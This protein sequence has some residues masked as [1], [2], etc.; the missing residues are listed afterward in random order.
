MG[1]TLTN[2]AP[3]LFGVAQQVS[4]EPVGALDG[5]N[6]SFDD[7][8]VAV[9]DDVKIPVAPAQ[10]ATDFTPG[11]AAASGADQIADSETVKITASKKVTW[12]LTGE[13]QR[14]LA[15]GGSD[16]EWL[17]Q[18]IAQGMRTLKNLA[19]ADALTAIKSGA[20]RAIGAAGTTPFASNIDD[21]AAMYK[22][23]RDNGAPMADLSLVIDTSA[24]FNLR[25]LGIIQQAYQAGSEAERRTGQLLKQFG[26]SIRE[27]GGVSLH[28]KGTGASYVTG[29]TGPYVKGVRDVPLVTG[30]GTVLAGD[31]VT[32]AADTNNKFI[33][34]TGIAAPGTI[35]LGRPGLRVSVANGNALT[36]GNN[37]TPNVAFERGA[38]VGAMRPPVMPE[39]PTIKQLPISDGKGMTFLLLEIAQYGQITWELHAAWGFK[40]VQ[41]EHVAVL[42]G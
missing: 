30:T 10:A 33:V 2:L 40:V 22:L 21:I 17:R 7:K 19:E 9:G 12:H 16:K 3:I 41:G 25:K 14:S 39:N 6:L 4:Q 26:F 23:L 15:N 29:A 35:K 28:T 31:V 38:V 20:S 5:I 37:Y 42:M 8:G 18:L 32:F 1:N 11:A 34:N 36:I 13:Q 27:S 24:G